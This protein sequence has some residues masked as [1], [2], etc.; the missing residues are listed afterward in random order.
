MQGPAGSGSFTVA[1]DAEVKGRAGKLRYHLQRMRTLSMRNRILV[2]GLVWSVFFGALIFATSNCE[3]QRQRRF[4]PRHFQVQQ[5]A[6]FHQPADVQHPNAVP[7]PAM[8][9][10]GPPAEANPE[11]PSTAVRGE[12]IVTAEPSTG[13]VPGRR[14]RFWFG[15]SN[16]Y[17]P[18]SY[19]SRRYDP[20]SPLYDP[21]TPYPK[22]IG[23]FHAS[24]IHN[25]GIPSGHRGF[26]GNGLYWAPWQ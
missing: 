6:T 3:A 17:G 25:L 19:D 24:E 13:V 21:T 15:P 26:R 7:T 5:P 16:L 11:V 18:E 2:K 20:R 1:K 14:P 12:E 9:K 22:Y 4:F 23:G 8:T 10:P